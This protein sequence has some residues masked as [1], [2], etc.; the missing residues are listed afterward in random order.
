ML[1]VPSEATVIETGA[2]DSVDVLRTDVLP[3]ATVDGADQPPPDFVEIDLPD[4]RAAAAELNAA[5]IATCVIGFGKATLVEGWSTGSARP[6]QFGPRDGVG[7]LTGSLSDCDRAG[8]ALMAI[9]LDSPAAVALADILLPG[10]GMTE[11]RVG[12]PR[13]HRYY[14][15]P[16]DTIPADAFS[17]A[18]AAS[19]ACAERVGHPGP[20]TTTFKDAAGREILAVKGTGGQ[21]ACPPSWH[22]ASRSRREWD[23]GV[24]DDP[25]VI[26][27]PA[28]LNASQ[29]L[30]GA[31]GWTERPKTNTTADPV[32]LPA[33]VNQA[34]VIGRAVAYMAKCPPAVEGQGGHHQLFAVA[35]AVVCGFN[36]GAK[37]GVELIT[38]HYNP[39][40]QPP[41]SDAEI[42]HKCGDASRLP[43]DRPRGHLLADATEEPNIDARTTGTETSA[44]GPHPRP[45]G[46]KKPSETKKKPK[47]KSKERA[48][49]ENG[50]EEEK[51]APSPPG[52]AD[53]LT[54]IGGRAELWH[55]DTQTG[56][57]TVGRTTWAINSKAFKHYLVC[58]YRKCCGKTPNSEAINNAR[59][60]L[61][62]EAVHD[63]QRRTAHVRV[64]G[65][66]GRIYLDLAD[67]ASTVIEVDPD[68]WHVCDQPPVRFV[69]RS[70]TPLPLP[71][72]GG[73]IEELRSLVNV[74]DDDNFALVVAWVTAALRPHGPYPM[75]VISGD[76]GSAKSTTA[77]ALR[78]LVHPSAAALRAEPS[79]ARPHDRGE[80]QLVARVR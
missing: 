62:A 52:A 49:N 41:W 40:C 37:A 65:H 66:D 25:A 59:T 5:G 46:A 43:Y 50:E 64:A 54:G 2:P 19:A 18:P 35:R 63:G 76:Q 26:A 11:G 27:Y 55:D 17:A 3:Q 48:V 38:A 60:A 78:N 15:V 79:N 36:L 13:S 22:A 72:C 14:L 31:C 53:V 9:D 32:E 68:G 24:R 34:S 71:V 51:G 61:E 70:G 44:G 6:E 7:I 39:R 16:W 42:A 23:S 10:T 30:A 33:N 20:K 58:E 56:Y 73:T 21:M 80:E 47:N 69:R 8:H 67:S 45:K 75:L 12:K 1:I 57:A 28:L 77:K 74:P 4:V 29:S